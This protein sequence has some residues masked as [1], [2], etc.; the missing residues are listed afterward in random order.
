[1]S[2]NQKVVDL[3]SFRAQRPSVSQS[4]RPDQTLNEWERLIA[5]LNVTLEAGEW[6]KFVGARR[7]EW[8]KWVA[9]PKQAAED[10][11]ASPERAPRTSHAPEHGGNI[12]ADNPTREEVKAQIDASKASTE[13]LVARLEGKIDTLVATVGG[14]M[15]VLASKID[16]LGDKVSAADAYNRGTRAWVIG[17]VI[18]VGLALGGVIAAM[19]SYGDSMFGHGLEVRQLV[20]TMIKE[21][22]TQAPPERK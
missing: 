2:D 7:G 10:Y 14:R 19:L 3:G 21:Q 12:M 9:A 22:Q 8:E 13:T 6:E 15:D 20:Q 11:L 17:T 4:I 16:A 1:M 5:H 18:T